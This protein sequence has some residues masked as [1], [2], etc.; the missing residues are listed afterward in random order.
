MPTPTSYHAVSDH[1]IARTLADEAGR[2][3]MR[4]RADATLL[5]DPAVLRRAGDIRSNDLLLGRLAELRPGDAVLSEESVDNLDRL[6]AE[7]VWIIDP[8]DGT[9]EFG[10]PPRDDWAVH[11]ALSSQG[12]LTAGAVAQPAAGRTFGTDRPP[13]LP[14]RDPSMPIRLAVSRTRPPAFVTELAEALGGELLPMGSA[15]VKVVAVLTGVADAYVHAGGQF[16]WDSA[17]PIAVAQAA[18]LHTSR[19]SG[20]PLCY[21]RQEPSLPDVLVCH[22]DVSA[23]VLATI[24]ECLPDPTAG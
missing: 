22:P 12:Q 6:T 24:L 11:V 19:V 20:G 18:G 15:G 14:V 10:E 16:E 9:R 4:L 5:S 23:R 7:R 3:L 1:A 17:A 13:A 21:N 2:L 8:L